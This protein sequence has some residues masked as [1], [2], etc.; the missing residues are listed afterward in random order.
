MILP[1][2]KSCWVVWISANTVLRI[3]AVQFAVVLQEPV[4]FAASIA[5]N[6]A[7]GKPDATDAEIVA[8]A[9]AAASHEFILGLPE[10]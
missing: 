6:I 7:Y 2:G 3:C 8:A 1:Q 9:Q 10:G 5:E 4:L